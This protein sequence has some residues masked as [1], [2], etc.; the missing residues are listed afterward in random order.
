MAASVMSSVD[1]K[2]SFCL[3]TASSGA[4][5]SFVDAG[6]VAAGGGGVASDSGAQL[7]LHLPFQ[8]TLR[9]ETLSLDVRA[10]G[11]V[12]VKL[13]ANAT[14]IGF[15]DVEALPP[16]QVPPP[17]VPGGGRVE[18]RLRGGRFTSATALSIFLDAGE[19]GV[20]TLAGLGLA[21]AAAGAKADVTKIQKVGHD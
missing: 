18:I 16:T 21:G 2:Q 9:L 13:W 19:D 7:L 4:W 1:K 11:P 20:L 12:K 10:L 14:A 17:L 5:S 15:D 8:E 6:G 3:N